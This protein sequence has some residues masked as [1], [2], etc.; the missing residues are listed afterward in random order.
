VENNNHG[1]TTLTSIK[2]Q[3]YW[4]LYFSKSY[5]RI[6]DTMTQKLGWTTSLRTK[7]LMIDKLAEFVREFHLGV[8]SDLII[9]EMF[10]YI[11]EDNGKTNAQVGCFD[12]TVMATAIMLQL[13]LEGKGDFY[14]PEIP[15][16]Q[17][18][19]V[20]REVVDELFEKQED[21]EYSD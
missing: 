8:Y 15:L 13:L 9:S 5:D 17:R 20:T 12:D 11:I 10:T 16:D 1:L 19:K 3:E 21:D 14:V 2:K 4:N 6:A 7:P 18:D